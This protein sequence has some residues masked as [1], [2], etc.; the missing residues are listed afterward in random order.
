MYLIDSTR[1]GKPIYDAYVNQAL[2][3]Y[4]ATTLRLDEPIWYFFANAPAVI[5]GK[6]QNALAEVNRAYVEAN[7]VKVVRRTSGGGAVYHDLGNLNYG[8]MADDDGNSFRNYARYTAPILEA[9][10]KLGVQD[11][12][13]SGRNDLL[14]GDKKF[15]GTSMYAVGGRFMVGG[16]LMLDVDQDEVA[17]VLKPNLKKLASKGVKSVRSRVT[18]IRPHLAKEHE[19]MTL[20]EFKEH[21]ILQIFQADRMADVKTYTLSEADWAAVDKLVAEQFGNWDWNY[22]HS[23]RFEYNRDQHFSI[24]TVEFSLAI[25]NGLIDQ[26]KVYGDFFASGS[27]ADVEAAL[28]GVRLERTALEQAFSGLDLEFYFGNVTA[29]DLVDLI[30]S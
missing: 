16:T 3:N 5:I 20:E 18:N 7:G 15:S 9:L 29:A 8:Y 4:F 19:D 26:C 2:A 14:I 25:K 27:I 23:P 13:L 11:A 1:D 24:G 6:N 17:K 21:L 10:H 28:V 22:G 30:L 12:H